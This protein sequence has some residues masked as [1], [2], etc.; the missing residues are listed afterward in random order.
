MGYTT[1]SRGKV[2]VVPPLSAAQI[3]YVNTFSR[4]RR[5]KRDP[6]K[7]AL[8]SDP[9]GKALNMPIGDDAGY[10]VG[11]IGFCGQDKDE[12]ILDSSEP[13]KGQPGLWCQ[14]EVTADGGYLQWNGTEKFYDYVEWMRYLIE[15]F[16]APWGHVLNG[17]MDWQ[18]ENED[19]TGV[20]TVID[21]VVTTTPLW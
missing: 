16:F 19:D 7:A 9:V 1:E 13:P 11:G 18:G 6:A 8:L 17:A 14:W 2:A 21:N 3:L 12:S 15:H 5:M 10:F 4:T 20:I